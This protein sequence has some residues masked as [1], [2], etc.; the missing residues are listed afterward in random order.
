MSDVP[1]RPDSSM[2]REV[3]S[4]FPTG[5]AIVGVRTADGATGGMTANAL[6]SLSLEPMLVLVCF[7]QEARTL[8][9]VTEA[10]RFSLSVLGEDDA[11]LA[12]RFASKLDEAEKLATVP[13]RDEAGVP[14]LESAIAWTVCAVEEVLPGGDHAI[15]IG[16]V[17]ALGSSEGQPLIWERGRFTRLAAGQ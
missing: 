4:R 17:E 5:V 13:H 11:L 16:R 12:Q 14:V 10:G 8:P 9:L 15:V 6:C 7:E 1:D 3:F 2:L